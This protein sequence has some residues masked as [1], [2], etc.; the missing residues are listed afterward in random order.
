[1][2]A[3]SEKF[4]IFSSIHQTLRAEEEL[5]K[6]AYQFSV[7]PIPPYVN[8]GCGL[9]IKADEKESDEIERFLS[10]KNISIIKMIKA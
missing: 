2:M 5:V 7:V 9:G 6:T 1:M 8:E 3:L 4:F 10:A